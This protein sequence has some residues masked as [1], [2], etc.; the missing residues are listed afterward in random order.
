MTS[1]LHLNGNVQRVTACLLPPGSRLASAQLAH[2]SPCLSCQIV[3]HADIDR[4]ARMTPVRALVNLASIIRRLSAGTSRRRGIHSVRSLFTK[5][6]ALREMVPDMLWTGRVF[7]FVKSLWVAYDETELSRM[8]RFP[9]CVKNCPT[10]CEA[11]QR[12]R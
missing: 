10:L 12:V 2:P 4:S 1:T 5:L 3:C 9:G 7:V 8:P 11:S 6:R